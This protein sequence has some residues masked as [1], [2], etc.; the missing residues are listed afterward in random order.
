MLQTIRDKTAGWIAGIF[1][2]AIAIVFVF[3]GIDFQSGTA[4]FAAK[5]DGERIQFVRSTPPARASPL[6]KR[7][8]RSADIPSPAG[9]PPA[10]SPTALQFSAQHILD[11]VVLEGELRVHAFEPAVLVL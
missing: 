5:V 10:A 8:E 3:W 1:L 11:R 9:P 7:G 6:G 2:G 4:S